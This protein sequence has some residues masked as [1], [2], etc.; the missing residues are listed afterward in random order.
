MNIQR[1]MKNS[2]FES[3]EDHEMVD[4]VSNDVE[5]TLENSKSNEAKVEEH[6]DACPTAGMEFN[7]LEDVKEFYTSFAKKEGFGVRIRSTKQNFCI[8]VCAN[9]G[10]HIARSENDEES[11]VCIGKNKKRCS[12]SRTDCKASLIVSKAWKRSKWVIKSITNVH[13]D[14]M[15]SPKSVTYL[16]CHKKISLAA[17]NLVEKFDEEGVPIG[18][19]ATMFQGGDNSFSSRDCWNHLRNLRRRNLDVGDAQAVF[20]FCKQK[21]VENPNFFYAIQ[22]DDEDR[23]INFFW[24]DGRAR[25]SYKIFGDVVT[26][27]TT[28]KTNKNREK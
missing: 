17:K 13:N 24:V 14:G 22:C 10:K 7:S 18:K 23:M 6:L 19:V 3:L 1:Y 16:R 11:N 28:Y 2:T 5:T 26:F 25:L 20:N 8:L 15:V 4:L 21:Q 9:E 27:D 12:T